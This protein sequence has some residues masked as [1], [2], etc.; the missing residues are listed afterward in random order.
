MIVIIYKI[1][2]IFQYNYFGY[3]HN[4]IFK[5]NLWQSYGFRDNPF[6]TTALA[7]QPSTVLPIKEAFIVRKDSQA[8]QLFNNILSSSGGNRFVLEGEVGVGKTTFVNYHKLL[9]ETEAQDTLF[10]P[11]T[12]VSLGH[13]YE[14]REFMFNILS[15]LTTKLI[16]VKG[17]KLV[18][19]YPLLKELML[20]NKVYLSH[21]YQIEANILGVGGGIGKDEK[22]SLPAVPEAQLFNYYQEM[23]GLLLKLGY[24]GVILHFDNVEILNKESTKQAQRFLE[25]IR[26]FLQVRHVYH[27]FVA[28]PGFFQQVIAPLPRVRSVFLGWPVI[29]SPLSKQE[30]LRAIHLRYRLLA[31][32]DV[33]FIPPVEDSFVEYL[34][35]IYEGQIRFIMDAINTVVLHLPAL[36][37]RTMKTDEAKP[38]LQKVVAERMHHTLSPNEFKVLAQATAYPR[39]TNLQIS[40]DLKIQAPNVSKYLQTL[41]EKSY[42]RFV[43]KEGRTGWYAVSEDARVVKIFHED[44]PVVTTTSMVLPGSLNNRQ[45]RLCEEILPGR[46]QINIE[47]YSRL[48]EISVATAR[49]DLNGLVQTGLLSFD[50]QQ[51]VIYYRLA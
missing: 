49:R 42:V 26:D 40:R 20:L 45:R 22:F 34:Y 15:L 8:S 46:G 12:E 21:S 39:F 4:M 47:E 44:Q 31:M 37:P 6:D 5:Q 38:L 9:W 25:E 19:K 1:D 32:P 14:I 17:E 43:G 13:A 27:V 7:S 41:V 16:L 36:F 33:R 28:K 23:I 10:T 35:E 48:M 51:R 24:H 3:Y 30:A 29:L 11:L 50:K 18:E 2:T